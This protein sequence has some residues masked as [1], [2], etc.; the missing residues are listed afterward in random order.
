MRC[1]TCSGAM[2]SVES[3]AGAGVIF[4]SRSRNVRVAF[5]R[6]EISIV[7]PPA[8]G[9]GFPAALSTT[10]QS[11]TIQSRSASCTAASPPDVRA[12]R[13]LPSFQPSPCRTQ[14]AEKRPVSGVDDP[15]CTTSTV[16]S[17]M[18]TSGDRNRRLVSL[19]LDSVRP[20]PSAGFVV[21]IAESRPF[22][23]LPCSSTMSPSAVQ[24][25]ASAL[26]SPRS[27]AVL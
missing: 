13:R 21:S 16:P 18:A 27:S 11:P 15:G 22:E 9:V 3:F 12:S 5:Q 26:P 17:S 7:G 4:M 25:A 23:T 10:V 8:F 24:S 14:V 20:A 19:I 6:T 2:G 1:V